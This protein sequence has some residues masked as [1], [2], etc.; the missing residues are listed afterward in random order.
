MAAAAGG[1]N[2]L[3][4]NEQSGQSGAVQKAIGGG[5][6]PSAGVAGRFVAKALKPV[7]DL[8]KSQVGGFGRQSGGGFHDLDRRLERIMGERVDVRSGQALVEPENG[9]QSIE[10]DG[11]VGADEIDRRVERAQSN[12]PLAQ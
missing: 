9:L 7:R 5:D 10:D 2:E 8:A 6:G 1:R 4:V 11:V 3:A 12:A